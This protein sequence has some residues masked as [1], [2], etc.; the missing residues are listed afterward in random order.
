MIFPG[1]PQSA[2]DVAKHYDE[3]DAFYRELW[4]EHVHHGYWKTGRETPAQAAVALVEHVAERLLP[5]PGQRVCDIGCGYAATAQ[6]LA[7]H[8]GVDVVGLT[9]SAVQAER[10][11][12]RVPKHG[13]LT[14]LQQDWLANSFPAACFDRSYAVESSEHMAD[15]QR[16]FDEAFRTL[17]PDGRFVVCAWLAAR[18]LDRWQIRHLLEPICREGRLPDM[19]DEA[20]YRGFAANAGFALLAVDDLSRQVWRTWLICLLRAL[21]RL[22]TRPRYLRF[23]LDQTASNRGFALT[24]VRIILAYRTGAM[25]YCVF[26]FAKP[27]R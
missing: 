10:A 5:E 9:L 2:L 24:L 12:V 15:K 4:G 20:D 26:T 17:K 3:L 25:R 13:S 7:D 6:H 22:A 19:G 21:A 8:Y 16:F 23:L 27:A 14:I 11:R 1:Q 18:D